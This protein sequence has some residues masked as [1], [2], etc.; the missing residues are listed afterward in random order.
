MPMSD[1]GHEPDPQQINARSVLWAG[2]PAAEVPGAPPS[3]SSAPYPASPGYAQPPTASGSTRITDH[4]FTPR[5]A[6]SPPMNLAG[7][8]SGDWSVGDLV[9]GRYRIHRV[10]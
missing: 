10:V 9:A 5:A 1:S 3:T 2:P 7:E 6:V 4:P 8:Q